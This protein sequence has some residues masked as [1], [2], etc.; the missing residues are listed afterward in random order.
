MNNLLSNC[1]AIGAFFLALAVSAIPA[2]GNTDTTRAKAPEVQ[3][4]NQKN[5]Q[6]NK[7]LPISKEA[8]AALNEAKAV[9]AKSKGLK[10][11]ARKNALVAGARTYEAVA[12]RFASED[13]ACGTAWFEAAEL[14]RKNQD[15][16]AAARGY[17]L[18]AERD[19]GRY[20]E[21]S[22]MQLA[23]IARRQKQIAQ[24]LELYKKVATLKSGT[25]R[26]HQARV[27]IGR[28]FER[29]KKPE[30]AIDAYRQA[31]G[32]TTNPRDMLEACNR[33]ALCLVREGRLDQAAAAIRQAETAAAPELA[34]PG[35][36]ARNL[37]RAL[38]RMSARKA[39]QRARDKV[40]G[41]HRDAEDVEGSR[42]KGR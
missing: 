25:A 14:W 28:C 15:F 40:T 34:R 30:Q 36:K 26:N 42:Q 13:G 18:A 1:P 38:D 21:R 17:G 11:E 33:L 2:Q 16:K 12:A 35:P 41:A 29:Q 4:N 31:A 5:N 3:K 39:L 27:W 24:A 37:R 23:H 22:W 6:K 9:A 7:R 8:R 32:S 10:G 19:P 20:Q